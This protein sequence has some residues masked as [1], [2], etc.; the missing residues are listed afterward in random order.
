MRALN[1]GDFIYLLIGLEWTIGL[2]VAALVVGSLLASLFVL[3]GL[4]RQRAI[5][6]L[7]SGYV[8]LFQGTPLIGQLLF[9]YFGLSI[10]GIEV[11]AF[12]AATVALGT[13]S[14]A[15]L[16]EIWRG[17]I[18]AIPRQ[19]WEASES[20]GLGRVRSLFDVILPQAIRGATPPTVG[21][22]VQL[23]K[24]TSLASVLGFIE[25]TRA[26]Q[27][28]NNSTFQSFIIF[29]AI[30]VLYFILCFPMTV[31]SRRLERSLI[32]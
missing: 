30:A 26:A 15:F 24:D 25:L 20:L 7:L 5:N 19:Q 16:S 8:G 22:L 12:V 18:E 9:F 6:A 32:R 21:F 28:I 31:L 2:S 29:G 27:V 10:I 13:Y 17:A 14:A 11:D 23:V 4:L 1:Q 3:L